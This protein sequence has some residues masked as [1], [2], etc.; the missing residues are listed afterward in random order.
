MII[1]DSAYVR[2]FPADSGRRR[3]FDVSRA[4]IPSADGSLSR[5]HKEVSAIMRESAFLKRTGLYTRGP[6]WLCYAG[7]KI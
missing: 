5:P 7:E 1:R 4:I 2:F 6:P 3:H